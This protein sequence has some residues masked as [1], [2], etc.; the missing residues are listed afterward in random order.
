[1]IDKQHWSAKC[2][3][4]EERDETIAHIVSECSQLAQN[5]YKKCRHDKIA[6]LIHW[7][8][9]KK[10]GFVCTE[11]S[12]G[13]FVEKNTKVLENDE[14]KLLWDFSIQTERRIEHNEPDIVVSR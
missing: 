9:C 1:M 10:F 6:A 14:V 11:K 8:Y 2:R 12:Y 7:K 13:H 5:E 4:C 3:M